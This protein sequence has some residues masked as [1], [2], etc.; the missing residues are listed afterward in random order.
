M[1]RVA[2]CSFA[3]VVTTLGAALPAAAQKVYRCTDA[4]G[5]TV[6]Q[7]S[8]CAPAASAPAA[9]AAPPSPAPASA[10]NAASAAPREPRPCYSER[11]I[12]SVRSTA[13]SPTIGRADRERLQARA[14]EMERCRR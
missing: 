13:S 6:F 2:A 14:R 7:Q 3:L 10:A 12:E 8:A 11:E 9:N 4:R 5:Q 1:R